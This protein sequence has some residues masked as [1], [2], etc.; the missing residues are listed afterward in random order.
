MG[1]GVAIDV[2]N[3]EINLLGEGAN[4]IANYE[5]SFRS[6]CRC[7]GVVLSGKMPKIGEILIPN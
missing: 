1:G 4:N 5:T 3:S 7:D 2:A 6:S